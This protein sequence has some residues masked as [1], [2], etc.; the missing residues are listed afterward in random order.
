MLNNKDIGTVITVEPIQQEI[1]YLVR[2]TSQIDAQFLLFNDAG[3]PLFDDTIDTLQPA[4]LF[5]DSDGNFY[6]LNADR[7]IAQYNFETKELDELP[8]QPAIPWPDVFLYRL[9]DGSFMTSDTEYDPGISDTVIV[10]ERYSIDGTLLEKEILDGIPYGIGEFVGALQ[11][12]STNGEITTISFLDD[13]YVGIGTYSASGMLTGIAIEDTI[14]NESGGTLYDNLLYTMA[15]EVV[16][17]IRDLDTGD[18]INEIPITDYNVGS[19][20]RALKQ[21]DDQLK[22]L[23]LSI[24][25][26]NPTTDTI[27]DEAGNPVL[28]L[29]PGRKYIEM[30]TQQNLDAFLDG[31]VEAMLVDGEIFSITN[32]STTGTDYQVSLQTPEYT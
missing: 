13:V 14:L 17:L 5:F 22:G 7:K 12:F 20:G 4:S 21:V 9:D 10:M 19:I 26:T 6:S 27:A 29:T 18:I 3:V 30:T 25:S 11:S 32:I 28:F 15:S 16:M 24:D 8:G 1:L 23:L 2:N 31:E